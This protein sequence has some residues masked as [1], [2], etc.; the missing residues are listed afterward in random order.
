M[1]RATAKYRFWVILVCLL[2]LC[3]SPAATEPQGAGS[4][5]NSRTDPQKVLFAPVTT[6]ASSVLLAGEK[7]TRLYGFDKLL[8]VI[9]R[10]VSIVS[11]RV[12]FPFLSDESAEVTHCADQSAIPI[13][14]P[15]IRH[16]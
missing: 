14:A 7:R 2:G 11:K 9:H 1:H 13:R 3:L 5:E 12:S 10:Q 4:L 15:P 6:S 16:A 8:A